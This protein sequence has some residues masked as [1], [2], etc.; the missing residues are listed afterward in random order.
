MLKKIRTLVV[1]A[2][3]AAGLAVQGAWALTP[4]DQAEI[5]NFTLTQDFLQRYAAVTADAHAHHQDTS[6]DAKDMKN[7]FASLDNLTASIVK[8][9]PEAPAICRAH[10][11]SVRQ[12]LVGGLVL[13]RAA[14]ADQMMADP[15]MAKYVDKSKTPSEANMAFYRT[16]KAEILAMFK[17]GEDAPSQD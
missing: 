3:L 17:K 16:H 9:A 4:A 5:Q 15:K 10:G 7:D 8:R 14:M 11:L 6:L 12:G 2:S 13:M 1:S